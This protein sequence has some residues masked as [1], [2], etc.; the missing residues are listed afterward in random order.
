MTQEVV[1]RRFTLLCALGLAAMALAQAPKT[2]VTVTFTPAADRGESIYR[3]YCHHCHGETGDGTGHFTEVTHFAKLDDKPDHWGK[4][5]SWGDVNN[6][7]HVDLYEGDCKFANQ[8]YLNNG[9]GTFT[10]VTEQNPD[11][12]FE[13][14]RTKGTAMADLDGNGSLDIYVVNWGMPSG[15]MKNMN[16]DRNWLEVDCQGIVSNRDAVGTK[17]RVFDAGHMGS[18]KHFRGIRV[19]QTATG[20]CSQNPLVQ[21]FGLDSNKTYDVEAVF[22]SGLIAYALYKK[23]KRDFYINWSEQHGGPP[24]PEH[25]RAFS[26]TV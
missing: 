6:D 15:L 20:F 12:K 22:P 21:H 3:T 16:H 26:S 10:N 2:K 8:L 25:V 23:D 19:V 7:G 1:M 4:G 9:D 18:K 14:V 11:V 24:Q 5:P 17:V 13:T